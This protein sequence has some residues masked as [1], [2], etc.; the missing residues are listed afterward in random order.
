MDR[1][2]IFFIDDSLKDSSEY[3][4]SISNTNVILSTEQSKIGNSSLYFSGESYLDI[5]LSISVS[6]DF[7][8]DWWAYQTS[9]SNYPTF[10]ELYNSSNTTRGY[11]VHGPSGGAS[12]TPIYLCWASQNANVASQSDKL[13]QWVHYALTQ[14]GTLLTLYINGESKC[15]LTRS[16]TNIPNAIRIGTVKNNYTT[17]AQ[18]TGY[19]DCFRISDMV[20]WTENFTPPE[21]QDYNIQLPLY[22]KQSSQW[23]LINKA[24]VK[25]D[26]N[27]VE[28]NDTELPNYI[29]SNL[30]A[31]PILL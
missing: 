5:S 6:G 2:T 15:T 17:A 23:K 29:N 11:F 28:L 21:K 4:H 10:F 18:Y 25:S 20:R 30:K 12:G 8:I 27:W 3:S 1:N 24:Y 14:V 22:I 9:S 7:T 26:G 13:N 31:K 19:I 16:S